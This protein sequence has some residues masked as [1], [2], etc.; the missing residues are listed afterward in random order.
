M[1]KQYST[2]EEALAEARR[3]VKSNFDPA[4]DNHLSIIHSRHPENKDLRHFYLED[5][6]ESGFM[7]MWEVEVWQNW[8][9]EEQFLDDS[10]VAFA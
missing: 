10:L 2:F 4:N 7:R 5:A 3:L 6:N 8:G 9:T 1:Q